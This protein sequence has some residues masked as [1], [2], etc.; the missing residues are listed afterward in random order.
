MPDVHDFTV[1]SP[2]CEEHM[3]QSH[4]YGKAHSNSRGGR[5]GTQS[6]ANTRDSQA[7]PIE[8]QLHL[9]YD[10]YGWRKEGWGW[11]EN[12]PKPTRLVKCVCFFV[13]NLRV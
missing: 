8:Q 9:E 11:G 2:G 10:F 3:V 4:P 6:K 13:L 1:P 12:K 7:L 5:E